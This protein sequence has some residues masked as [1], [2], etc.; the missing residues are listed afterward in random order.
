MPGTILVGIDVETVGEASENY[1]RLGPGFFTE[2][3]IKGTW[4]VTGRVL[5]KSGRLFGQA[6]GSGAVDIQI[7]TYDHLLLKSVLMKVPPGLKIHGREDWFYRAGGTVQQV[8][9]DLTRCQ[10]V[11]QDIF[12]SPARGLTG[13][14]AYYRGLG[15]RPDLLD[16]V[17]GLGIRF[18]RTFGRDEFDGQPVPME[19]QPYWYSPQ[20]HDDLLELMIHDYQDDFYYAAFN[21]LV[22]A[23]S[24]PRHLCEVADRVAKE[25]LVWSLCSHDH[26]CMTAEAFRAKTNW[27]AQIVRYAK[28]IGIRFLT[29]SEYYHEQMAVREKRQLS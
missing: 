29:G 7:H 15:D 26:G 3:G 1:A 13:P 12:G 25:D 8:E 20:G 21:G 5:E 22:D 18:L 2:L 19:W 24:Y 23:S 27:M 11:Y 6:A 4:Y 16:I 9:A 28:S 10:Q 17:H 14:W